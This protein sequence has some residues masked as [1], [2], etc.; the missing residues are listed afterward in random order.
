LVNLN[1]DATQESVFQDIP[2]NESSSSSNHKHSSGTKSIITIK[3][4]PGAT[5]PVYERLIS[6][7]RSDFKIKDW[8]AFMLICSKAGAKP[9]Y[10]YYWTE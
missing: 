10:K 7:D 4:N 1:N 8:K 6:N 2:R 9:E 3:L 5:T